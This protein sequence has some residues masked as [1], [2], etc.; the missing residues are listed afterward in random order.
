MKRIRTIII[1]VLLAVGSLAAAQ[2]GDNPAFDSVTFPVFS[3]NPAPVPGASIA[4]VGQPGQATWYFWASANYQLG[5]V[6]S[7][8]GSV[9]NAPNT[10]S[11][12]NYISII[13]TAYP[14]GVLTVDIL[15]TTG[16]LAPV[17]ACN[18]AIAT[19]LTSGGANF[20][21]NTLSSYTVSILNPQAFNL[22]LTNEVTGTG[23]VSLVLRNAYTGALICNL[24]TGCGGGTPA[25]ATGTQ[26]VGVGGTSSTFQT[27]PIIDVR[28]AIYAGGMKCDG[29]TNDTAA[30]NAAFAAAVA[31]GT[32]T[33]TA[34]VQFPAGVCLGNFSIVQGKGLKVTGSG[35]LST[36][37]RSPNANPALNIN[38]LW[39]SS[40]SDL[41]FEATT[42]TTGNGVLEIDGNYDGT[43]HQSVQFLT[44]SSVLVAGVGVGDGQLSEYTTA[45]CRQ[46]GSSC[47]GSNLVFVN[48]AMSGASTAVYYQNGFNSLSNQFMGGDFQNYTK[49]GIYVLNG[50]VFLVGGPTFENATGCAQLLNGGWDV[51]TAGGAY[52]V[53]VISGV[54]SQGWNLFNAPN[55]SIDAITQTPAWVSYAANTAFPLNTPI[56]EMGADGLQHLYCATTAGTSASSPPTWPAS[57]TVTDGSTLVW[58]E[59]TYNAINNPGWYNSNDSHLDA[60]ASLN[61]IGWTNT[62]GSY[63]L[64]ATSLI[65]NGTFDFSKPSAVATEH[66]IEN[67][68]ADTILDVYANPQSSSEASQFLRVS[69]LPANSVGILTYGGVEKL[70]L[71]RQLIRRYGRW[72]VHDGRLPFNSNADFHG[73]PSNDHGMRNHQQSGRRA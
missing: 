43:H 34:Y 40:F 17:G 7:Y 36:H 63:A 28:D 67:Q 9:S 49:D 30:G 4:L 70:Y 10:L 47:Q 18:C 53:Q 71:G 39:Y 16:P 27:K 58:T 21:S 51:H 32:S 69:P 14:A 6:V 59:E 38:G 19:G 8:L 52:P 1:L 35:Q 48:T 31:V 42:H 65:G 66:A 44:F 20:Q 46:G 22:R 11:G 62:L 37:L 64:T 23:A 12:S 54:R 55:A 25:G 5:S 24:S 41:T 68:N 33:G 3:L 45:V 56:S 50:N 13:P 26:L 72:P 15:A 57:G 29:V 60:T 73:H 2:N 61:W